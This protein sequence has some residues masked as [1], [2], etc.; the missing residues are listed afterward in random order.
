MPEWVLECVGRRCFMLMSFQLQLDVALSLTRLCL[1]LQ[2]NLLIIIRYSRL[3]LNDE[4]WFL[5][6]LS[7]FRPLQRSISGLGVHYKFDTG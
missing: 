3:K 2:F 6:S 5:F 4:I 7:S 1:L